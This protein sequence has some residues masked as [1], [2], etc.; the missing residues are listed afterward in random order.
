MSDCHNAINDK[1]TRL[2]QMIEENFE[3][4]SAIVGDDN[5]DSRN[6]L[7]NNK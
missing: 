2:S 6:K 3:E 4:I 1:I 5:G 7:K